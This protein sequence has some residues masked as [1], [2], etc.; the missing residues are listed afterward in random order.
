MVRVPP[1]RTRR[2]G[3]KLSSGFVHVEATYSLGTPHGKSNPPG[4]SRP[5]TGFVHQ[6]WADGSGGSR[7]HRSPA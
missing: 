1:A 6:W 5:H 3:R 2:K 4:S 7:P